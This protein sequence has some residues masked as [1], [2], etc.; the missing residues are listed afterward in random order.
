MTSVCRHCGT[1]YDELLRNE[2][3]RGFSC[4]A[5]DTESCQRCVAS[6]DQGN[7]IVFL[8]CPNCK[9]DNLDAFDLRDRHS[10]FTSIEQVS[11]FEAGIALPYVAWSVYPRRTESLVHSALPKLSSFHPSFGLLDEENELVRVQLANWFP[12]RFNADVPIGSG[13]LIWFL[14]GKPVH[15]DGGHYLTEYEILRLSRQ[16]WSGSENSANQ[17]MHPSR[18]VGRFDS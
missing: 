16:L 4:R 11:S 2:Q 15:C 14:A 6:E 9:A 1:H 12:D 7:Q 17:A 13:V 18:G 3:W 10:I 5:C 8:R